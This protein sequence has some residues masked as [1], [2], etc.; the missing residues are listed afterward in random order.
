MPDWSKIGSL[1]DFAATY[2]TTQLVRCA[3]FSFVLV[4]LVVLLRKVFLTEQIFLRG[5][6]WTSFLIIPFL[7]R[8]KLFYENEIIVKITWYLTKATMTWIWLDRIYM[9]GIL[10]TAACI[11]GKRLQ[12]LKAVSKMETFLLH[13]T[14]VRITDMEITPFTT[15]V[16][17]P[18]I[19]IP[20]MMLENYSM[21]E[22]KVIVEHERTH[23]RLGHLWFG[24]LWDILRCLL[25]VNP[26][27]TIFQKQLREDMEDICDRVCIQNS[28]RAAREYGMVLLKTMKLLRSGAEI[29]QPTITY[30]GEKEFTAIK[31][32]I[33]R[34]AGFRSYRK[35]VCMGMIAI[36]ALLI[37]VILLTVHI[38]SYARYSEDENILVYEYADGEGTVISNKD[39]SIHR[40]ISYDDSY[41]YVD[42]KA[43]EELLRES[44]A[45]GQIY[46][47]FGGYYKL[48]GFSSKGESC[49]Y[50]V[51]SDAGVGRIPYQR[52]PNDWLLTLFKFL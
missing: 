12:L 37:V 45:K 16:L 19:V 28:G 43:F 39:N 10:V 25:L 11:L 26:F 36:D 6:L 34:I 15:G 40:M 48:P 18:Q 21:E 9:I 13:N 29:T 31:R 27:L 50:K 49:L 47:V 5:L 14:N 41:V 22:L 32:R 35:K 44:N 51:D 1:M 33:G 7:G 42:K 24:F 30:A 3:V 4:W 38:H 46:I 52:Q 23:I 20:R 8:L 17:K 2:Y